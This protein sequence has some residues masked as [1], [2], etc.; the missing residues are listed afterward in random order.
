MSVSLLSPL[1]SVINQSTH[2]GEGV[3]PCAGLWQAGA[4]RLVQ[5]GVLTCFA[6]SGQSTAIKVT[7]IAGRD[8][9]VMKSTQMVIVMEVSCLTEVLQ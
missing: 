1:K 8:G 5:A 6:C 7:L 4:G 2:Q 3:V 9:A